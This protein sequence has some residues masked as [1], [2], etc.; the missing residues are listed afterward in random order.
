MKWQRT[1]EMARC[2]VW[3]EVAGEQRVVPVHLEQF[4]MHAVSAPC[5]CQMLYI[6]SACNLVANELQRFISAN[7]EQ[8]GPYGHAA[9]P[10][11]SQHP[12]RTT[13]KNSC[14]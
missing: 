3:G 2:A 5:K 11:D 12:K 14:T 4:V 10:P 13:A 8:G 1:T 9:E 6:T 7:S